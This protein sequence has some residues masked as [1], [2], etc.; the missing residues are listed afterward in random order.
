MVAL[1][2]ATGLVCGVVRQGDLGAG[3]ASGRGFRGVD[4]AALTRRRRAATTATRSDVEFTQHI[5]LTQ[6]RD[7]LFE[8]PVLPFNEVDPAATLGLQL[9]ELT[10]QDITVAHK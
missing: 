7:M 8:L 6:I 3:L 5:S 4:I 2:R 1:Y 9:F 10:A